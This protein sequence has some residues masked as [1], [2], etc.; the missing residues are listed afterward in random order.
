MTLMQQHI[1]E[2]IDGE[3]TLNLNELWEWMNECLSQMIEEESE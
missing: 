3:A 2:V 1:G